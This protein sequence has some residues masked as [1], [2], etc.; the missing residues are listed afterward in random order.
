MENQS[1]RRAPRRGG[2]GADLSA[3]DAGGGRR[4]EFHPVIAEG[5]FLNDKEI[6]LGAASPG[7]GIRVSSIDAAAPGRWPDRLCQSG[8]YPVRSEEP[9]KARR[10]PAA[11]PVRVTGL[12]RL[13]HGKPGWLV[14]DNRPD[15]NYWFWV[16]LPAMAKATGLSDVTPFYIDADATPKPGGWPKGGVTQ[17]DLPNDHLQ[18][19]ITWFALAA[20]AIVV[21]IVWRRQNRQ[22]R[23]APRGSPAKFS[24][25]GA[26]DIEIF[27][28][29]ICPDNARARNFR[30]IAALPNC[31]RDADAPRRAR[32][33]HRIVMPTRLADAPSSVRSIREMAADP[34][35][36]TRH[37]GGGN[38][39]RPR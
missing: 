20:A 24:I 30:Y 11:G 26:T 14:P 33:H 7:G 35:G 29:H 31:L 32:E 10:R 6:F 19:A 17:I 27:I 37:R 18:Y 9:R 22:A 34:A 38:P 28:K 21:Y 39:G 15:L 23:K 13:P 3:E 25:V 1:D 36:L 12:L 16:D 5:V 4:L 2:R 8:L